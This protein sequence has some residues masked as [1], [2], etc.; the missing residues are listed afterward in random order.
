MSGNHTR[1]VVAAGHPKTAE[2]ARIILEDGG[3]A[4]DAALAALCAACVAEPVLCS[5]GGGGF[6]LARDPDGRGVLYDFFAQTPR[7][8]RP[9]AETE[10]YPVLCDFGTVTQEFHIGMGSTATP[11]AVRGL[12]E[13]HRD[14]GRM[15]MAEIVAPAARLARDGV[16]LNQMQSEIFQVVS[17]IYRATPEARAVFGSRR[18]RGKPLQ[19]GERYRTPALADTLEALA[20]EGDGLFYDGEIAERVARQSLERGGHVTRDDL[21]HY[22]VERRRPLTLSYRDARILTNPPPSTGGLL[23]AFALRLI[24]QA[25]VGALG[26]GSAAHLGLLARVM[27][28]TNEARMKS[29]LDHR[30]ASAAERALFDPAL[31]DAY[32]A[33]VQGHALASRGTT[34]IS[35]IDRSGEAV[36]LSLSNGEGNGS[37][38]PDTGIMLNNVL[39]EEDINPRGF[40]RWPIG[41]RLASMMAPTVVHFA[42]GRL[43]AAGSGGSNRIRTAILQVLSNLVDFGMSAEQAVHSPRIHH[44]RGQL[45][46]EGGYRKR[47]ID[48]L[49]ADYPDHRLWPGLSLFFGGVHT[50]LADPAA[51]RFSGAGDPRR[52]GVALVI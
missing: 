37:L 26:H 5:L 34:H 19:P 7:R 3:N 9:P 24:G 1:G 31:L 41:H 50:A 17:P 29:R 30:R 48:R 28:L 51:G 2:A 14:L 11:G 13:V 8:R 39:G 32:A 45:G 23:I 20:V 40:H 42:D 16:A 4:V 36:S 6:L 10:F 15:P 49:V 38:V 33:V 27:A 18:R 47:E 25:D 52:D 35:V 46:V 21:K 43:S 22:R 44:E 12:F